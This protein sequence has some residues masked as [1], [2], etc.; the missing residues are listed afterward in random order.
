MR[1]IRAAIA[2]SALVTSSIEGAPSPT[3]CS[4]QVAIGPPITTRLAT[5]ATSYKYIVTMTSSERKCAFV[6]YAIGINQRRADG[7]LF[8]ETQPMT[9]TIRG[10]RG[11][12][13]F[14]SLSTAQEHV[15]ARTQ[16]VTCRPCEG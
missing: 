10:G 8:S 11:D 3:A 4:A 12:Q 5:G 6:T 15:G 9:T 13:L 14:E 7:S 1:N 2:L 16:D